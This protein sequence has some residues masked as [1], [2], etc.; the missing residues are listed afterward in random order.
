MFGFF[1]GEIFIAGRK[2]QQVGILHG[3]RSLA[4]EHVGDRR[5]QKRD[6]ARLAVLTFNPLIGE[7]TK[8]ERRERPEFFGGKS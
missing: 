4:A 5:R 6:G 1:F 3:L 2:R 8:L 7:K